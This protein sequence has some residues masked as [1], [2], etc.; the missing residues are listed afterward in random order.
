MEAPVRIV[1]NVSAMSDTYAATTEAATYICKVTNACTATPISLSFII[2][3]GGSSYTE[4]SNG[5]YTNDEGKLV[6][7]GTDG[8]LEDA[9]VYDPVESDVPGIYTDEESGDLVYTGAD[10]IPGTDDDEK[11]VAP[12]HPL[13]I[14]ETQFS[15]VYPVTVHEG[16]EY[17]T[18]L[19]FADGRTYKNDPQDTYTDKIKFIS[20]TPEAISIDENGVMRAI[21]S[22]GSSS[23]ITII[24]EDGSVI[25]ST[26]SV[27]TNTV[28]EGNKLGSVSD[29]AVFLE[30]GSVKKIGV[31]LLTP[32]NSSN[33]WNVK[34][35]T[36]SL[37]DDSDNTGSTVTPGG[38]FHAGSPGTVIVKATAIDDDDVPFTGTV[39]VTIFGE[40]QEETIPYETASTDWNTLDP[41]PAYAGGDGTESNPYKISSVRQLK[42]LAVDIAVL[43]ITEATYQKYFELTTD[44][45]F[46]EDSSV[47]QTLIGDFAGYLDG[48][49]HV[50]RNLNIDATGN[51]RASVFNY[52]THGEIKNLGREGGSTTGAGFSGGFAN[53]LQYGGKLRN[54]Y[55][56]SS[57][58]VLR[59][60]G[61]LV[62]ILF[63]GCSIENCY[64]TGNITGDIATALQIGG[65]VGYALTG[66]G[67][68]AIRN[69]YNTG[70]IIGYQSIG[71]LIGNINDSNGNKQILNMS[72]CFNFGNAVMQHTTNSVGSIMGMTNETNPDLIKVNATNVYSRP[73][74]ASAKGGDTPRL[75]QPIGFITVT[76]PVRDAILA[77]NPTSLGEN[78][79][80]T[81]EYS[82]TPAFATELGSAFK[83]A[84]GRTPKLAWEK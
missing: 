22:D 3:E 20:N 44:L 41:A 33:V 75:N 10:G 53:F 39:T 1:T 84:N 72:N 19:D 70:D 25:Y 38:W 45:D 29:I 71:G 8:D 69:S 60:G 49:G 77:A 37:Y 78:E 64:N 32:T 15:R 46:S 57:V 82:K 54:C 17:Q 2:G 81:L 61:G 48:K 40:S 34:T 4:N 47:K 66:G 18:Q 58:N 73:N 79:K 30:P 63:M 42:K 21:G 68:A 50:I 28:A 55:N 27:R 26:V 43:G 13:P 16:G 56:S 7:P 31:S 51:L 23:F 12:D 52:I 36:Y 83:F 65:L 6:V 9:K 11:F 62:Q 5:T 35:L 80:Y 67:T 59:G 14:Q 74:V 24:L 76:I